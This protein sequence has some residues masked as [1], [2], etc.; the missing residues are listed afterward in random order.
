MTT[1][2]YNSSLDTERFSGLA[3]PVIRVRYAGPTD[4]RGSRYI[5][6]LRGTRHTEHYDY[7]LDGPDNARNAAAECWKKYR[8]A[9]PAEWRNDQDYVL[10]PGDL[11]ANSYAFTVVPTG[12]LS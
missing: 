2:T 1:Q 9:L 11:D 8:E 10:I 6:T 12:F 7:A 3:F 4:H 5:A